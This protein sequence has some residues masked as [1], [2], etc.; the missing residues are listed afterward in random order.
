MCNSMGVS[1]QSQTLVPQRCWAPTI[2]TRPHFAILLSCTGCRLGTGKAD[3]KSPFATP[4]LLPHY[5]L[6]QPQGCSKLCWLA[7]ALYEQLCQ[8]RLAYTPFRSLLPWQGQENRAGIQPLPWFFAGWRKFTSARL[9]CRYHP[10]P[11]LCHWSSIRGHFTRH[12]WDHWLQWMLSLTLN[13]APSFSPFP[14]ST[15]WIYNIYWA[16]L[17]AGVNHQSSTEGLKW[18]N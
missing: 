2:L 13:Q 17:S 5:N 9:F 1:R 4:Q 12:K 7:M 10:T 14:F 15:A 8:Q 3:L 6:K 11:S 16:R 18:W